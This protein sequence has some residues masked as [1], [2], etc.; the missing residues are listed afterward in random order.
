MK[1]TNTMVLDVRNTPDV[2]GKGVMTS[3]G[4]LAA[5]TAWLTIVRCSRRKIGITE[6]R[7]EESEDP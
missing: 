5:L 6:A 7:A 3:L 1:K 4:S 2:I